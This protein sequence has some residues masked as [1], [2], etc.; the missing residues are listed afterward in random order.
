MSQAPA[1]REDR[2]ARRAPGYERDGMA[3][4]LLDLRLRA[5]AMLRLTTGDRFLDAACA[6]CAAVGAAPPMRGYAVGADR[7]PSML[8]QA[9]KRAAARDNTALVLCDIQQLPFV[10]ESFTAVLCTSALRCF[11]DPVDAAGELARVLQPGG[12]AVIGD[13]LPWAAGGGRR[14]RITRWAPHGSDTV[15]PWQAVVTAGLSPVE[16]VQDLTPFG[17]YA[18]VAAI[19]VP[20][21]QLKSRRN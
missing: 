19:K 14:L 6:T 20:R 9:Q 7:S 17:F 13:F 3:S 18:I 2:A 12:R 4:L 10:P 15:T 11:P 1:L 5:L 8:R 16:T 21:H